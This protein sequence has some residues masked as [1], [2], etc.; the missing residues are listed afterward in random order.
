MGQAHTGYDRILEKKK[1]APECECH[2][3][4]YESPGSILEEDLVK[5]VESDQYKNHGPEGSQRREQIQPPEEQQ[6]A[7]EYEDNAKDEYFV[8][9]SLH[10]VLHNVIL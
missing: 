10:F 4:Q 7:Y 6:N 8:G 2:S 5:K 9:E 3:R 1:D